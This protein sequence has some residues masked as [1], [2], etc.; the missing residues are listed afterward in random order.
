MQNITILLSNDHSIRIYLLVFKDFYLMFV[1][2]LPGTKDELIQHNT[3][4][5]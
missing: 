1:T 4:T 3:A 2:N 5:L